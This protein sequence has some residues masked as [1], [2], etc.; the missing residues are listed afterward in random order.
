[1]K[2]GFE[3]RDQGTDVEDAYPHTL[4]EVPQGLFPLFLTQ[5]EF[6]KMLDGTLAEPFFPRNEDGSL[7]HDVGSAF[8][9]E[10]GMLD[11]MPGDDYDDDHLSE[12][13]D[14]LEHKITADEHPSQPG[15]RGTAK[16]IEID[17]GTFTARIW[18]I[19]RNSLS[20]NEQRNVS[21]A[22]LFQ[23]IH[24]Y[25]KGSA[26]ALRTPTGRLSRQEYNDLG[27]KMAP[28]FKRFLAEDLPGDRSASRDLV[29]SLYEA[30]EKEKG[31]MR[32]YDIS[33]VVFHIWTQLEKERADPERPDLR[34]TPIA[35]V[36]VDETQDFT[37]AELAVFVRIATEK[38][39]LFFSGDTCQT[40]ASGVG[41][42]FE[43]LKS[44]F[45]LEA[46]RQK[47]EIGAKSLPANFV[48][49]IPEVMT[50]SVNYRCVWCM[51]E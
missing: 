8:H 28:N 38:N 51:R 11:E 20:K 36:F 39:D 40:I 18:P 13:S 50:L 41:F 49:K 15:A 21:A 6:L 43:D 33:D 17:F 30:Y 10:E 23:E 1:M 3:G 42:R 34:R 27:A 48:V 22:S 4:Q 7:T 25:I 31:A 12:S 19:L 24:S 45:K 16:R 5:S 2:H 14:E 9:E 44:V 35:S 47:E 37:Q 29:Y 32:G 46:D 26:E